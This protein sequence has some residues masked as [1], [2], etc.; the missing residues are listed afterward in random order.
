LQDKILMTIYCNNQ[1]INYLFYLYKIFKKVKHISCLILGT[2][3]H[4]LRENK[5]FK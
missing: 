1:A 2:L 4:N 5:I 3:V